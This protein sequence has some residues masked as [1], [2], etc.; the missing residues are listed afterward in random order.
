MQIQGTFEL[1]VAPGR[2]WA[3]FWNP[4]AMA[5]WLP[6]CTRIEWDGDCR[7]TGEVEQSVPQ[8]E[9]LFAFEMAVL[10]REPERRPR[11]K[12]RGEG[13][14]I[15][16]RVEIDMTLELEPLE[17][18]G[19]RVRYHMDTEIIGP[20]SHVGSYILKLKAKEPKRSVSEQ[21]RA[22]LEQEA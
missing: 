1:N 18:G 10:E 19:T 13:K 17:R 21:V 2:V 9:A 3:S 14:T 8:R 7:L 12:G 20:I 5:A 6:G 15:S 11:L 22:R 4:A 16:S